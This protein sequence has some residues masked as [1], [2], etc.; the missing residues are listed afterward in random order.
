S[1]TRLSS[2]LAGERAVGD[3]DCL[4][5]LKGK[6]RFGLLCRNCDVVDDLIHLY[7]SQRRRLLS[8]DQ[9]CH[10]VR[11]LDEVP[12]LVRN[13]TLFVG[14]DLDQHISGEEHASALDTLR[15]AHF[16]YGLRRNQ[17]LCHFIL[18]AKRLNPA[19]EAVAHFALIARI[20]MDDEP[21]LRHIVLQARL[22]AE[23]GPSQ[24]SSSLPIRLRAR[25]RRARDRCRRGRM[26]RTAVPPRRPASY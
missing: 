7:L 11:A 16:D 21:L 3:T 5:A 26:Q 6:L 25:D 20:G 10:L 9:T 13:L 18:H 22:P 23:F 2:A 4:A 19:I 14:L 15:A 1:P 17:D 24:K 8:A 12:C